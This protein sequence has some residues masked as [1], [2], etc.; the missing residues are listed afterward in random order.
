[1]PLHFGSHDIHQASALPDAGPA[2]LPAS[3]VGGPTPVRVLLAGLPSWPS[4]SAVTTAV[5]LNLVCPM[6][7]ALAT[8]W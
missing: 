6:A 4:F 7:P 3:W 1:M 2:M 5:V 8:G